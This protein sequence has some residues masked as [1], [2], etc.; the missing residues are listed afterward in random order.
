MMSGY[1]KYLVVFFTLLVVSL[2]L[3]AQ[4]SKIVEET[5]SRLHPDGTGWGFYKSEVISSDKPR[6]LFIGDSI[7]VGYIGVVSSGLQGVAIVDYWATGLY[8][9]HPDLLPMLISLLKNNSYDIIHF[10]IGL[11]GW[12]EGRIADGQYEPLMERYIA[13]LK[14]YASHSQLIWAST[15]EVTIPGEPTRLDS[16]INSIIVERNKQAAKLMKKHR[17]QLNDLYALMSDRLSLGRGDMV[18]WT[19]EGSRI[20]GE[21]VL[22]IVNRAI[23]KLP[24]GS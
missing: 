23:R 13:T 19:P 2:P 11:H 8:E 18:H 3:I 16:K 21:A 5:D 1:S 10:N 7:L 9:S 24:K 6:V 15:T 12:P 17:I 20:Q 22:K 14:T 4:P